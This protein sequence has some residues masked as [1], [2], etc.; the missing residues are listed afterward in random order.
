[1]EGKAR[2]CTNVGTS[3]SDVSRIFPVFGFSEF[4]TDVPETRPYG[5]SDQR[6]S[7]AERTGLFTSRN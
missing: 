4:Q 7:R 6:H 5:L 3:L 2:Y 1:M